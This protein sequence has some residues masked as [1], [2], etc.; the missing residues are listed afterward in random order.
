MERACNNH[1][2]HH[3]NSLRNLTESLKL[4]HELRLLEISEETN[5]VVKHYVHLNISENIH[6]S[7]IVK[8]GDKLIKDVIL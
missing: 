2:Y 6:C 3:L 8:E 7:K 4:E 1:S 5:N